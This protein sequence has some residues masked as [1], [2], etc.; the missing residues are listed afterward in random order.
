MKEVAD[1]IAVMFISREQAHRAH[2]MTNS[3]AEHKALN[4]FYDEIVDVADELA[5]ASIGVCGPFDSIPYRL[6]VP[7][8]ID[9]ALE[10]HMNS[11]ESIRAALDKEKR[12]RPLQ[13]IV[14]SALAIYASTLYKLRELS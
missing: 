8:K 11:I 4:D 6:A 1:I 3:Y 2:L 12:Y 9:V 13:N 14:D 10:R 5:E 7:G